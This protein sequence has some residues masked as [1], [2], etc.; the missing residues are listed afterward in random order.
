MTDTL[1]SNVFKTAL[2]FEGGSMRAAYTCAVVAELLE[3]GIHFDN[4]YGVS[5]G[6]SNTVN[7]VSRDIKR[8]I[9]SFTDFVRL[10][11]IGDWKTFLLHK[12][13]FN[14]HY[15]YQEAGLPDGCL[16]F[17]FDTFNASP[18]KATIAAFERDTGRDLFFRKGEM[19]SLDELMVRVR[20]SSTVPILMPPPKVNGRYCYDGGF[21]VGGGLPLERIRDDGFDRVFVVR[22]RPRGYRKE[23]DNSW[24]NAFFWRRPAMRQAVLTRNARYNVACDLLDTWEREGKAY[25]FYADDITLSGSERDYDE[26][27]RNFELGHAQIKREWGRL[28]DFLA[29]AEA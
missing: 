22:T 27:C 6:S 16:P 4:V 19:H 14:A 15:I 17:D 24:A 29:E 9:A 11:N 18:A 2:L 26:L 13:M 20:A 25:V 21:A 28:L 12:G 8:A 10:D 3:K 1:K 23:G 5:A 7:Y